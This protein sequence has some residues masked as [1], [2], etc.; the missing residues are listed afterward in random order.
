MS[1]IPATSERPSYLRVFATFARNSLVRDMTFRSNFIIDAV[2]SL[3]WML[4]QLGFYILIF[5]YTSRIGPPGPDGWEKYQFFVFIATTVMIN[6]VVQAFF[7]P[8]A[9]EFGELIRTGDLDFALLKPID[10]QFLISLRKIEWSSLSNLVFGLGLLVFSLWRLEYRPHPVQ[11]LL[12]PLYLL[13]GIAILY[14]LM[15]ALASVSVW[16]GRN[17]SLYDFWFY[18]T[19]FSRYPMEI[20]SGTVGTP[21]RRF[22]TYGIPIL[23]VVN[24]PARLMAKPLSANQWPLAVFALAATVGSLW[25]SRRVFARALE[26]YR[27]ASS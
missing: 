27:S 21:L 17:Q 6:S 10:A 20:Y 3:A 26:S 2:T 19:N 14:S 15:I 12:Y 13:C 8:N 5:Q 4:T 16:L 25:L 18:I 11:C 7:M 22:F 24:V 23:I 1:Q 9:D